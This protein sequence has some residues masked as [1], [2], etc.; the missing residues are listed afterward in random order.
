MNPSDTSR[1][2]GEAEGSRRPRLPWRGALIVLAVLAGWSITPSVDAAQSN[3]ARG[4]DGAASLADDAQ[5]RV[6]RRLQNALATLGDR[7]STRQALSSRLE[8]FG[9]TGPQPTVTVTTLPATTTTSIHFDCPLPG[10]GVGPCPTTTTVPS[11]TTSGP[12]TTTTTRPGA[13]TTLPPPTTLPPCPST[14]T[15]DPPVSTTST[16][17]PSC[18]P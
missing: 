1:N 11:T 3:S 14:T 7:E 6:C 13:T 8:L 15:T 18:V 16:S 5:S 17:V 12:T 4:R 9:C 10:G 2:S